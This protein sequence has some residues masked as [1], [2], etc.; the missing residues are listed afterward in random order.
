MRVF[1]TLRNN[2]TAPKF[3][4]PR[5]SLPRAAVL[6]ALQGRRPAASGGGGAGSAGRH[7]KSAPCPQWWGWLRA[8]TAPGLATEHHA[9]S[10]S[11]NSLAEGVAVQCM[12]A[13]N[14]PVQHC[15]RAAAR[16]RSQQ[17]PD[18]SWTGQRP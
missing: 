16:A 15:H 5:R 13:L 1:F 4:S 2:D 10:L 8:E 12:E 9:Q 6:L 3:S 7:E 14:Q 17:T 11:G 18:T